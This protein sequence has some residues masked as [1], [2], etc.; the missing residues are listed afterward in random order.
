MIIFTCAL[1]YFLVIVGFFFQYYFKKFTASDYYM[2]PELNLK[3]VFC[4]AYHYF[5]LAYSMLIFWLVGNEVIQS[6]T[7]LI[8][9]FIIILVYNSFATTLE[10]A[11]ST[12]KRKRKRK[13][14]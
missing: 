3:R 14:K 8:S 5:I 12:R 11:I 2:N 1:Y 13:W 6:F 9:V 10:F 7:V 4:I